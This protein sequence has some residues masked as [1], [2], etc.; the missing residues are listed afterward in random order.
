MPIVLKPSF[1][2]IRHFMKTMTGNG[3]TRVSEAFDSGG[4]IFNY[5][6]KEDRMHTAQSS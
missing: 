5:A 4:C 2:I 3:C 1:H 6:E